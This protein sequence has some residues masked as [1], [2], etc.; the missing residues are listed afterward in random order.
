MGRRDRE[1]VARV[2]AGQETGVRQRRRDE[3]EVRRLSQRLDALQAIAE[4]F[5]GAAT[6]EEIRRAG[7]E[8]RLRI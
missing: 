7:Q 5:G 1:R 4:E 3:E 8:G 6:A 2:R